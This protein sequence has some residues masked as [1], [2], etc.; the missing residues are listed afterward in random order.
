[1]A[2]EIKY[3]EKW[4]EIKIAILGG[5]DREQEIARLAAST[6]ATVT[7]FGF[8]WPEDGIA[9]VQ[10]ANSA[11]E[12]IEGA[13]FCFMPIPG[14]A[15]DG[16]LFADEKIIPRQD[17]LS[18][19]NQNSHIILGKAD[20][21]LKE[22][23]QALNIGIH[24]YEH[25][26]ELMLLR[27]PA[28]VEA[29]LRIIIENTAFTIHNAKICI[30]GMGNVGSVL[31][32]TLVGLGA[33]VTVAAR[34]PVQRAL[35]YTL[36]A[37]SMTLGQ[38]NNSAGSFDIVMSSV[39]APVVTSGIIDGFAPG[40]LVMDLAAPPGGVDLPYARQKGH[41]AIWARALGRRAPIT[42]GESQWV[43]ITKIM[44]ELLR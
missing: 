42:V 21:G 28:I 12:C 27:A 44:N 29:A 3:P 18:R 8:P 1:M 31:C 17:L 40:I 11:E 15:L 14:I 32:K 2:A 43:G 26:N 35:A 16:S 5:D 37:E 24:E 10:Q 9:G 4:K 41:T 33:H 20:L 39:P 19:M 13:D 23:A 7:A 38:L 34:N 36:G 22:A 25:D 6:G 30:V